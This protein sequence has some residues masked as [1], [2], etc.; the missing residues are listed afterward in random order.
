MV[1]RQSQ[2]LIQIF[3]FC[4]LRRILSLGLIIIG[5]NNGELSRNKVIDILFWKESK[6]GDENTGE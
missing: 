3:L 6:C 1:V 5:L 4:L 2:R